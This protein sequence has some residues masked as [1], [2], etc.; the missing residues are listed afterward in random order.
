MYTFKLFFKMSFKFD[1]K[2]FEITGMVS[3][4]IYTASYQLVQKGCLPIMDGEPMDLIGYFDP[5]GNPHIFSGKKTS[6][7]I[8]KIQ[9]ERIIQ[10]LNSN[11]FI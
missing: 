10:M 9:P 5:E 2:T 1:D 3:A 7:K 4:D 11:P 8:E 6:T